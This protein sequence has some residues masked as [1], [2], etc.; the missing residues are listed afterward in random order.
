LLDG[1][2]TP[3]LDGRLGFNFLGS[4]T[5]E[6]VKYSLC[7]CEVFL[8]DGELTKKDNKLI[9]DSEIIE[10]TYKAINFVS[11]Y[12]TI[13]RQ[14]KFS[15]ASPFKCFAFVPETEEEQT[16]L[17]SSDGFYCNLVGHFGTDFTFELQPDAMM[18]LVGRWDGVRIMAEAEVVRSDLGKF[19]EYIRLFELAFSGAGQGLYKPVLRFLTGSKVEFT[20]SEVRDWFVELRGAATHADRS[21]PIFSSELGSRISRMKVA[22][23]DVLFNKSSWKDIDPERREVLRPI[24]GA[25]FLTAGDEAKMVMQPRDL[26]GQFGLLVDVNISPFPDSVYSEIYEVEKDTQS[27][28]EFQVIQK[29]N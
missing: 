24:S 14:K 15:I 19:R 13:C 3:Q 4:V 7:A 25:Q 6:K 5:K 10:G 29:G 9:L 16:Y 20:K 28:F 11:D 22:A 26:F 1:F 18:A 12:Y 27:G 23:Y 21:P 17:S 8:V 2:Q